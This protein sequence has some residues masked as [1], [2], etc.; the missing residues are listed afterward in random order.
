MPLELRD[1]ASVEEVAALL[2]TRTVSSL[3]VTRACL[4]RIHALDPTYH[5]YI[6]VLEDSALAAARSADEAI[7]RGKETGPLFGVP[8]SVKDCFLLRGTSTTVGSPILRDYAPPEDDATCL[9]R[10]RQAGAVVLGK[11]TVGTGM[12]WDTTRTVATGFAR[13]QNPW[14]TG[15]TPG[16]SSSGSAVAVAL[17][18]GYA[19][20]GTDSG[21]SIRIPAS[22]SGV[23]GLKPTHGRVSQ[24]GSV[25]GFGQTLEHVGPLTRTVRDAAILL[26]SLAGY[27]PRDS[28]SVAR[29]VPDYLQALDTSARSERWRIG[30][31]ADGGP[32]GAE[33]DVLERVGDAVRVL[34]SCGLSV[35]RINAP[36]A[37][38]ELWPEISLLEES[39]HLDKRLPTFPPYLEYVRANLGRRRAR[40]SQ[41]VSAQT[42]KIRGAYADLFSRFNLL[43]LPT[44]PITAKPFTIQTL[45]WNGRERDAEGLY[46]CNTWTF[47]LTGYPAISV[48]CG[49]DR[50]GLPVGLQIAGRHFDETSVLQVARLYEKAVGGFPLPQP[51]AQ[52]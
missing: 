9:H 19:S 25:Y 10:L 32:Q 40:I 3:E 23:V 2:R 37:N 29:G 44:T 38:E 5:A 4:A 49:F 6:T 33:P 1:G 26:H 39:E 28:T 20:V 8:I 46:L 12:A 36:A 18:M 22:F 17:G 34:E 47:N 11:T 50:S 45:Q 27:D 52:A 14:R 41:F 16:G 30:W 48:P 7:R 51:V 31:F 21:G 42:Q 24:Y 35:E 43:V 13:A 15:H